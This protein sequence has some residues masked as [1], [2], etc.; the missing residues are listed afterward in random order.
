MIF[1][2]DGFYIQSYFRN[3]TLKT[4]GAH[5]NDNYDF[6]TMYNLFENGEMYY[7]EKPNISMDEYIKA[8]TTGQY[9]LPS[10]SI[11]CK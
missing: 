9:N 5:V 6:L 11:L 10:K 8:L 2:H 1:E 3:L 7:V 4:P